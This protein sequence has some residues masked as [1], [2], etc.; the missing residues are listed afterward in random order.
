MDLDE[1]KSLARELP[2]HEPTEERAEQLRANLLA[3]VDK[4][5]MRARSRTPWLSGV[6]VAA[7]AAIA[8]YAGTR[9]VPTAA[10]TPD[11][12]RVGEHTQATLTSRNGASF[13]RR[14]V[15][16]DGITV[17]EVALHSGGLSV[18]S[19]EDTPRP[20]RIV[21]MDARIVG[22]ASFDIEAQGEQL[23]AI[24][25]HSGTLEVRIANKPP[26]VLGPGQHWARPTTARIDLKT[27]NEEPEHSLDRDIIDAV[28]VAEATSPTP[29][30][31]ELPT[32]AETANPPQ[33]A[34]PA[35]V[36][37]PRA[38]TPEASVAAEPEAMDAGPETAEPETATEEPAVASA[39]VEADAPAAPSAPEL[40]FDSGYRAIKRGD[41]AQGLLELELAIAQSTNANLRADARYW[42]IV[43]LARSGREAS[44]A[45]R[46][47]LSKHSNASRSA[48]VATML[49]WIYVEQGR[50]KLA[51]PLFTQGASD[52]SSRVRA[53][54][55]EGLRAISGQ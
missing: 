49:G 53:S 42:R 27:A 12:A 16:V 43:A 44:G 9:H 6:A 1:L 36:R 33:P 41:F 14:L 11:V 54:A 46:E 38:A 24:H 2:V 4:D 28:A 52:A 15:G 48:E 13:E 39:P 37:R 20:V 23:G 47:F 31:T 8:F 30:T 45:M 17:E 19:L 18:H 32:V 7:V 55:L 22:Q 35:P 10:T 25:V 26:I 34:P 40:A 21:T 3:S 29:E 50:P 51:A 5:H